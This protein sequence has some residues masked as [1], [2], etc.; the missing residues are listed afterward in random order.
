MLY[1]NELVIH[2]GNAHQHRATP[3]VGPDGQPRAF[4]LKPRDYGT[5]PLGCYGA[6]L[7]YTGVDFPLIPR[8]E[9]SQRAKDQ[10]AAGARC[11]DIRMRGNN[12]QKIP[13][14]D[15]NGKGYCWMHSGTSATLVV[16]A[17]ANLAYADLSAYA[18]ACVI[19]NFRDE[20]GWGAQGV[21]FLASRGVP[22]SKFWPQQS[23]SKANDKPETWED[24]KK[25]RVVE[26]WIDLAAAQ[27]DRNL[28]FEQCVSLF[29]S[30]KPVVTD[31][32][33]WSHSVCGIDAIDGSAQW[34]LTRADSGK[35]MD[36]T[37]F[38]AFWA[39]NDPVTAGW[40]IRIWNSWGDTW[41]TDGMGALTGKQAVP[42]GSVGV[43]TSTA[44]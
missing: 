40:G 33:W 19:K 30:G 38:E 12:G 9:W 4:G 15:Q 26:G 24:A 32:N 8:G 23:M 25:H 43:L 29:L 31:F 42:D 10:I 3:H 36:L 34:G 37:E 2:D 5:H 41:S 1:P 14:R 28:S 6:I 13:S 11:S 17:E 35:L 21:D 18:C 27:Y 20:G 7:P 22:T 44:A 39:V 16:R